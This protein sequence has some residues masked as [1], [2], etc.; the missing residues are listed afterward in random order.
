MNRS[1]GA[2]VTES[3]TLSA[4]RMVRLK[5]PNGTAIQTTLPAGWVEG[6]M[7]VNKHSATGVIKSVGNGKITIY[8][9]TADIH[10]QV[11]G[12]QEIQKKEIQKKKLSGAWAFDE[13]PIA[14]ALN[15]YALAGGRQRFEQREDPIM[16]FSL[17]FVQ[18]LIGWD[19]TNVVT[20]QWYLREWHAS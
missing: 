4:E 19:E 15:K 8:W 14:D 11:K 10:K 5:E 16:V 2:S 17:S 7:V 1:A 20:A 13:C 12:F 9:P 18:V 3:V 6:A